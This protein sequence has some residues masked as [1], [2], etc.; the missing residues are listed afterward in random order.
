M[1]SFLIVLIALVA[2]LLMAA[3]LI[4]NPKG[5][6]IDQTFSGSAQQIFGASRSADFI[7][8]ATWWLAGILVLLCIVAVLNVGTS[9]TATEIPLLSK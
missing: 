3:V 5:G 1:M 8:Q 4:Q 2:V 7:E 9:M 6:G